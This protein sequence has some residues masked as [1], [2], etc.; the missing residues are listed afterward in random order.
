M[1]KRNGARMRFATLAVTG[2]L[3]LAAFGCGDDDS[4][5]ADSSTETTTEASTEAIDVKTGEYYFDLS[6]TPAEDT[7]SISITNEGKEFHVMILAKINEGFT[8]EEAIEMQGK[9]GSAEIVA[10]AELQPGKT[11]E[12]KVKGPIEPGS[13]AML[14]PVGGPEGP[15]YELGQL[16]EFDVG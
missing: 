10:E 6:A 14:C 15:H 3:G 2:G 12:A 7:K 5:S 4:T 9:K 16:E 8:T 13:Y 1:R 11:V